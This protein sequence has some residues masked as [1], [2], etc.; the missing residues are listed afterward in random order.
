MQKTSNGAQ[1]HTPFWSPAYML[2]AAT[3]VGCVS[4]SLVAGLITVGI[5]VEG[6]TPTPAG[7]KGIPHMISASPLVALG[8]AETQSQCK[9]MMGRARSQHSWLQAWRDLGLVPA[10]WWVWFST[11]L[12]SPSLNFLRTT[13]SHSPAIKLLQLYETSQHHK[14]TCCQCIY[15]QSSSF[16]FFY[17]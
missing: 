7:C 10:N 14:L 8:A 1:Q 6:L 17:I 12:L 4:P 15:L 13:V 2:W 11:P 5:L 16:I 9:P 3:Y